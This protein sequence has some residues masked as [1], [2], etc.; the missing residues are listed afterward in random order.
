MLKRGDAW[1]AEA[2]AQ[3]QMAGDAAADALGVSRPEGGT[4]LFLDV[5]PQLDER[6]LHGF[7]LDCIDRGLIL[8][9]GSSCGVA[10]DTHVRLC[11]TS[12]P[13]DVVARGVAVLAELTGR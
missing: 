11:F 6:G 9:P 10:Y 5:A 8:A 1:L 4:F 3:Y 13:P 7:M 12:A 2:S